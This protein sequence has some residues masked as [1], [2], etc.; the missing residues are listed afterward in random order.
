MSTNFIQIAQDWLEDAEVDH[1]TAVRK[2]ASLAALLQDTCDD[3]LL[4]LPEALFQDELA[5]L[6]AAWQARLDESRGK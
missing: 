1:A 5:A 6:D 4:E 3:F 2:S